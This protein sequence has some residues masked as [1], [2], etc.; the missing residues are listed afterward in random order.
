MYSDYWAPVSLPPEHSL[1]QIAEKKSTGVD[2]IVLTMLSPPL[3]PPLARQARINGDVELTLDIR[4]DGTVGSVSV[5]SGHPILR[6]AAVESAQHSQF[7]CPG[8]TAGGLASYSL[9]YKF[10][11]IPLDHTKDCTGLTDEERNVAPPAKLDSSQH[12][13]TVFGKVAETCDPAVELHR[14]RSAKCLYLWKC[15]RGEIMPTR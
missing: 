2:N 6:P 9:R 1:A 14:V 5:V 15:G 11:L 7:E 12:E 13:I 10:E 8:C 3:Y 4:P